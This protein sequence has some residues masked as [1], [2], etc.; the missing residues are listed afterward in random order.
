MSSPR[1]DERPPPD[2]AKRARLAALLRRRAEHQAD[3]VSP[4]Q[5]AL[6]FLHQAGSTGAAYHVPMVFRVR[7]PLDLS[8]LQRLVDGILARH[9]ALRTVY[10]VRDG[11]VIQEVLTD[12][13]GHV[14]TL[15]L[16]SA[17][18]AAVLRMIEAE[19]AR[20]FDLENGPVVR[21][22]VL[23]CA[24]DDWYLAL[25][26]HHIAVDGWSLGILLTD[27]R[28]L[29]D[30][31]EPAT[32]V[33]RCEYQE[34]VRTH[35]R[36]LA[37][38]RGTALRDYW[39]AALRDA[40]TTLD[41]PTDH[42]RTAGASL[43][44]RK[45]T[46]AVS[47]AE[48]AALRTFARDHDVT[49]YV[50]LLAAF[51]AV[52][53]GRTGRDELLVATAANGRTEAGVAD[54][55]G[56]FTNLL[57]L[58]SDLADDPT[59][60]EFLA[61]TSDTVVAALDH[62]EYPFALMV[63][64]RLRERDDTQ[65][66]LVQAM[67]VMQSFEEGWEAAALGTGGR[68]VALGP[69]NM[70]AVTLPHQDTEF[71]MI[72]E[73]AVTD[74]GLTGSLLYRPA[75]FEPAS[76]ADYV[77]DY[78]HL[79]T[80]MRR[81]PDVPVRTLALVRELPAVA[82]AADAALSP[83]QDAAPVSLPA[84][85]VAAARR[86]PDRVAL[87][88]AGQSITYAGLERWSRVVAAD[89]RARGVAPDLTVAVHLERTPALVAAILGILRAGAAYVPLEPDHPP[90]R[91]SDILAVARPHAILTSASLAAALPA[92]TAAVLPLAAE[93]DES[94][95][96]DPGSPDLSLPRLE[97]LAYVMFTSASTGPPKGVAIEHRQLASFLAAMR[98]LLEPDE[99]DGVLASTS[100]GFDVSIA[101]LL[102]P[103]CFGGTVILV[104]SVLDAVH[105]P[106]AHLVRTIFACPSVVSELERLGAL[107]PTVRT[108]VL[109]G[110]AF[111]SRLV[112]ALYAH[113]EVRRVV[114]AYGPTEATVY[115]T[116]ATLARDE[117]RPP[118]LGRP[119]ANT[120][121]Y[122]LDEELR[123]VPRGI[124]GE[125]F[126]AGDG[127]ARGYLGNA[128]ETSARFMRDPFQ[129]GAS[130]M[131]RTG[132][133]AIA[134]ADGT[135]EFRG[136][137][138][139][140]I[141]LHGVRIELG[142]IERILTEL[143][144][145]SEAVVT[146]RDGRDGDAELAAYVVA[147]DGA[148]PLPAELRSLMEARLPRAMVPHSFLVLDRLPRSPSG[149]VDRRALP[150]PAV[151]SR[152]AAPDPTPWTATETEV[153]RAFTAVL[154]V[155]L[156][157]RHDDFFALGGH[158]LQA[159][160]VMARLGLV[161]GRRLAV[162]DLLRARTVATL[163]RVIDTACE[164]DSTVGAA[165]ISVVAPHPDAVVRV[166]AAAISY[167]PD[168]LV[169]ALRRIV[170]AGITTS[171]VGGHWSSHLG[172]IGL[173]VIPL[174]A[175]EMA[176]DPNRAR[177]VAEA[178][179]LAKQH[180]AAVVALT[181]MLPSLTCHGEDVLRAGHDLDLPAITTGHGTTTAAVV[182][183]TLTL[184]RLAGVDL[185]GR[186][187]GFLGLGAI[188]R[189]VLGLALTRLPQ[190]RHVLLCD[191]FSAAA[192]L[193]RLAEDVRRAGWTCPVDIVTS[194]V[195]IGDAFYDAD[196]IIGA[197]SVAGI[198]DVDRVRP[199][200]LIVDDS[201][202]HCFDV[203]RAFARLARAG[204]VLFCEAGAVRLPVGLEVMPAAA[205]P[206]D[207]VRRLTGIGD[208]IMACTLSA[209]L[210]AREPALHPTV[211]PVTPAISQQHAAYLEAAGMTAPVP[212]C[213]GRVLAPHDV[214]R[215]RERFGGAAVTR[216]P[217]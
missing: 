73:V 72:L 155:S 112:R 96:T 205:A 8:L 153:A 132:D 161:L 117:D 173:F 127:V 135:L 185:A 67:F 39:H 167:V 120:R 198:L 1:S 64:D 68:V 31:D 195:T 83:R 48:L 77:T 30:S 168:E 58:R 10:R 82:P 97:H 61:R 139:Q 160:H 196:V 75:L 108:Y 60:A 109:A 63:R 110:E 206:P 150:A 79:L 6:Y 169:D 176:A 42:P 88:F 186:T 125:I 44:G 130:R 147:Q 148:A 183:N 188:G 19:I 93:P 91:L 181:G 203:E 166:D 128:V 78:L 71:D 172:T 5:E 28:T 47:A 179:A 199:G 187:L 152:R 126:L 23:P 17:A 24:P 54:V 121:L 178:A 65:A 76:A 57:P 69:W 180:G 159:V 144:S 192:E 123:R 143:P 59:V 138:D 12:A 92:T 194:Q 124:V 101:D 202:P 145:V 32:L 35:A 94:A 157:G 107:P 165:P 16:G 38:P 87:I 9:P 136:R 171:W 15:V 174:T 41:L 177:Q 212:H 89:L 184:G 111:P 95:A 33:S 3:A 56:Y 146:L 162:C 99:L 207:L 52:L 49:L 55:V 25:T 197:S 20:P 170:P 43:T 37:G 119:L 154:D 29:L 213:D 50:V 102:L 141:K 100:I 204:D 115:A 200:T 66:P 13:R 156:V 151:E 84:L 189:S 133:L 36:R 193:E 14:E 116:A 90:A 11:R 85:F 182:A 2:E 164:V 104:D 113:P 122:L 40:P 158:S 191:V 53:H 190:P 45:L 34:H 26:M 142:E 80:E 211:G 106:A 74:D 62:Q 114:N 21:T 163:A 201:G 149:K 81:G 214:A 216:S 27:L 18:D 131:F 86:H 46:F 217:S 210:S 98:G 134:H 4:S 118:P 7:G 137:R 175:S 129:P 140:Q 215:F 70:E 208:T 103:L 22:A 105:A 209:L 51:T